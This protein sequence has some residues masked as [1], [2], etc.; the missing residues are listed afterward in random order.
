[1]LH[2]Y[3]ESFIHPITHEQVDIVAGWP[4]RFGAWFDESQL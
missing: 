3:S 1:M 4:E 2:A